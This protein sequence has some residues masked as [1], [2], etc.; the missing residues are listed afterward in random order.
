MQEG[1]Q[2]QETQEEDQRNNEIRNSSCDWNIVEK[3]GLVNNEAEEIVNG[4]SEPS[5]L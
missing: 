5:P 3:E 1:I 2:T 4:K